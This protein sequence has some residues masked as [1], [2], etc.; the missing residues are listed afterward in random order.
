MNTIPGFRRV[1]IWDR[2]D[3]K[4]T[5]LPIFLSESRNLKI[6]DVE[7]IKD[8]KDRVLPSMV[9]VGA[10]LTVLSNAPVGYSPL[11]SLLTFVKDSGVSAEFLG[12]KKNSVNEGCYKFIGSNYLGV[13]F[14]Y[15]WEALKRFYT[16][17]LL[18]RFSRQVLK[19]IVTNAV[20][21]S[22]TPFG[23]SPLLYEPG[24]NPTTQRAFNEFVSLSWGANTAMIEREEIIDLSFKLESRGNENYQ[25]AALVRDILVTLEITV[26]RADRD[27]LKAF[28]DGNDELVNGISP[29]VNYRVNYNDSGKFEEHQFAAG[30]LT[31]TK[32]LDWSDQSR[33]MKLKFTGAVNPHSIAPSVISDNFYFAYSN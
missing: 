2:A 4:S 16:V 19:S 28:W 23:T 8:Y 21:A 22:H 17:K 26:D 32:N 29:A 10:D 12:E 1:V 9:E 18:R 27:D 20:T 31:R 3:T 13:N 5:V 6:S 30:V 33:F 7:D 14:T 25:K 15:G 11:A 24:S